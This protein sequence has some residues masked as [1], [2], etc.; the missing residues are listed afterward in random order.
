ML[1]SNHFTTQESSLRYY[2]EGQKPVE[3]VDLEVKGLPDNC[4][5]NT[6]K[7]VSGSKHVIS[8]VVDEDN[9]KGTCVGTGRIQ[10][11]LSN[12]ETID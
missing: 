6:L 7:A 4:Q 8:A 1:A 3:V 2:N 11:R 5:A 10:L 12:G 9:M